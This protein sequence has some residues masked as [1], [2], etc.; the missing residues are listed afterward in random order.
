MKTF[1]KILGHYIMCFIASQ[2]LLSDY[3]YINIL[4][5]LTHRDKTICNHLRE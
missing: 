5:Y 2:F 1:F 4:G 3:K